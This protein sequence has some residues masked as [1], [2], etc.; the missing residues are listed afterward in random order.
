MARVKVRVQG[1]S[2]TF[3]SSAA[4]SNWPRDLPQ[5][6]PSPGEGCYGLRRSQIFLAAPNTYA[7]GTLRDSI[8]VGYNIASFTREVICSVLYYHSSGHSLAVNSLTS[9]FFRFD[10][11]ALRR[12][13]HSGSDV[14]CIECVEAQRRTL[15]AD[16]GE[17]SRRTCA[18]HIS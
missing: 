3:K 10:I 11:Y 7:S 9:T 12:T 2:K 6:Q 13:S 8:R 1:V 4:L 15:E 5:P 18:I 16:Y 17:T 14:N